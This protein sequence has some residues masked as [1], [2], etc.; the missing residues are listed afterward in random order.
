MLQ[1]QGWFRDDNTDANFHMLSTIS[2]TD[3]F[4]SLWLITSYVFLSSKFNV[5][6]NCSCQYLIISNVRLVYILPRDPPEFSCKQ[7]IILSLM[8]LL[9]SISFFGKLIQSNF[10]KVQGLIKGIF[11][12][13][14]ILPLPICLFH[15]NQAP[16]C[17]TH[18]IHVFVFI[19]KIGPKSI[20]TS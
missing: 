19:I 17:H 6:H 12:I 20:N 2:M 9:I 18:Q 10:I 14:D 4:F 16:L 13:G 15:S 7:F 8:I 11:D 3:L 1:N 5:W